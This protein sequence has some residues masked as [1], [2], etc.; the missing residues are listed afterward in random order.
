MS[1]SLLLL[2]LCSCAASGPR[3]SDGALAR[4][5]YHG[6][7][8]AIKALLAAGAD[9]EDRIGR[10]DPPLM[11]MAYERWTALQAAATQG[12]LEV[13]RILIRAGARLDVDDGYGATALDMALEREKP[14]EELPLLL[15]EAGAPVNTRVRPYIDDYGDGMT[16]ALHRAVGGGLHRTV[17]AM[18]AHGADVHART[19]GRWTPL[20]YA[21]EPEIIGM[22]LRAGAGL[23]AK[24]RSGMTPLAFHLVRDEDEVSIELL[25][26]GANPNCRWGTEDSALGTA[27]GNGRLPVIRALVEAGADVN[28]PNSSG[29]TPLQEIADNPKFQDA[30]ILLVNHGAKVNVGADLWSIPLLA[31]ADQGCVRL[32]AALLDHGAEIQRTDAAGNTALH[33]AAENGQEDAVRLLLQRGANPAVRNKEGKT[34]ADLADVQAVRNLFP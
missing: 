13:A 25:K 7:L 29:K 16:S 22:L 27:V 34:P 2:L 28:Y 11:V 32:I 21:Y 26:K 31:A 20:F 8:E 18:L 12:H 6:D 15:I 1:R 17:A 4:A 24:D 9:P 3:P 5:A 30:A 19:S 14:G 33:H 10:L 23:E